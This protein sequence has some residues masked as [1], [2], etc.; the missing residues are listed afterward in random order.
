MLKKVYT[1]LVKDLSPSISP[2]IAAGRIIKKINPDAKVVFIGPCIAKKAEAKE[3][4]LKDV[5]DFV[6]TFAELD[7][8]FK[9]LKIDLSSLKGI[10]SK[11]YTSRGGRMYARSG[12]VSTAVSDIIEELYPDKFKSFKSSTASGVKE[13][14]EILEK[15][16][17]K[18]LD[19]NF[20]EGMG[21]KGGCVGGPKPL[22]LLKKEN[23]KLIILHLILQ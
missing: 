17:N 22:Y 9:A 8:I 13:C 2:M 6:L 10:P 12:G 20:I 11:D 3:N 15:A 18:E 4:D 14:I 23:N 16:L 1:S 21:C 5:I 7:E 19:S